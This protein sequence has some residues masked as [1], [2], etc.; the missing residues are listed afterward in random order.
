MD[1][2]GRAVGYE[3]A[4]IQ[5]VNAVGYLHDQIHVVLYHEDS[6]VVIVSDFVDK[7]S[8]VLGFLW[9]H[10]GRWFVQKKKAGAEYL[11][12]L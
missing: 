12:L 2:A 1:L 3:L 5:H 11:E 7:I 8:Q 6:Q 4:E 10:A 9:I